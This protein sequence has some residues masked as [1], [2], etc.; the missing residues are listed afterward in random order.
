MAHKPNSKAAA[1]EKQSMAAISSNRMAKMLSLVQQMFISLTATP[2]HLGFENPPSHAKKRR[3][4]RLA[5]KMP[6]GSDLG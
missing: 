5:K 4:N 3:G 1:T 6:I 2:R